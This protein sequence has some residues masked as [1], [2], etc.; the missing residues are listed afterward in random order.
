MHHCSPHK[1]KDKDVSES[2]DVLGDD[3]FEGHGECVPILEHLD[4]CD[5]VHPT[6]DENARQTLAIAVVI[7]TVDVQYVPGK[8]KH[9]GRRI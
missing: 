8:K 7:R 5:R 1:N 9:F 4:V 3:M 2:R 6:E